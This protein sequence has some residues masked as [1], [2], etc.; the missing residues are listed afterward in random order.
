MMRWWLWAAA[1]LV[2]LGGPA[3][4]ATVW[5]DD[6]L[7]V[8][9]EW[10]KSQAGSDDLV[11]LHLGLPE[12]YQAGHIAGARLARLDMFSHKDSDP[13]A[14]TL[15][16]PTAEELH[17]SLTQLGI[18]DA[19]KVVVYFKDA[20]IQSA[21][22]VIFT[23]HA[24]GLGDRIRLLDGGF[25][26]WQKAGYPA[27]QAVPTFAPGKLSPL[28]MRPAVVDAAFVRSH[29]NGA[30]YKVV[31]AR[32]PEF[33]SGAQVGGPAGKPHLKGHIAG[34]VSLPYSSITGADQK[35]KSPAEIAAAFTAA[36]FKPGD[37]AIVYCHIG[38]Q[39]SAIAFAARSVGIDALLYDG[40]FQ[41]WSRR[42]LPVEAA[43]KK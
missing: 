27:A 35:L 36:G 43:P 26:A 16:L 4:A 14:L 2:T 28:Q 31:D 19:S 30:G 9:A 12:A 29:L 13:D 37:K 6:K 10:L 41:D 8:T 39:A 25:G 32:A 5:P 7:F 38:Q 40:S 11:L 23:F 20:P 3:S 24:A 1:V 21:T 42:N 22:R 18:S 33:Y 17:T 15:E 34:A